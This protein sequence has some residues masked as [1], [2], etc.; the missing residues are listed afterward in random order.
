M[1]HDLPL[2]SLGPTIA[3]WSNLLKKKKKSF[4]KVTGSQLSSHQCESVWSKKPFPKSQIN[5]DVSNLFISLCLQKKI[6]F[7]VKN[8]SFNQSMVSYMSY[9][10]TEAPVSAPASHLAAAGECPSRDLKPTKQLV[11]LGGF[12]PQQNHMKV[13]NLCIIPVKGW[14]IKHVYKPPTSCKMDQLDQ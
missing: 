3:S 11:L 9:C 5:V 10:S 13:S 6:S 2:C 8:P 4:H 12:K 1:L 7:C 14:K